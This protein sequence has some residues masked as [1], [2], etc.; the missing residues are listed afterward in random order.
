MPLRTGHGNGAGSPRIEVLPP[1]ELPAPV[2]GSPEPVARRTDGTVADS[3]S[4]KALG[5]RGG[6]ARAEKGRMLCALG[7]AELGADSD[8]APYRRHGDAFVQ[9][10]L[11]VLALQSGGTVGPGPASIVC[12]AGVQLAASRFLSDRGMRDGDAKLLSQASS[13]ANDSRQNLLAAYELAN[14]EAK[15]RQK[16]EPTSTPWMEPDEG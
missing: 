10:H 5:R 7:L 15:A 4:A 3:A 8:F 12:S 13:L 16:I 2:P 6:L 14:R 1:D 11:E 9:G